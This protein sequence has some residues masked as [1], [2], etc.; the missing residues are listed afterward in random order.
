MWCTGCDILMQISTVEAKLESLVAVMDDVNYC[1]MNNNSKQTISCT[2]ELLFSKFSE[3]STLL[4]SCK[5]KLS[6]T[7]GYSDLE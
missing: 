6:S 7:E 4:A 3:S 2:L 5:E 1:V